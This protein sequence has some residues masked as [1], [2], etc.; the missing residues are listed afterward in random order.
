MYDVEECISVDLTIPLFLHVDIFYQYFFMRY[1]TVFCLHTVFLGVGTL[2][3][4]C[5]IYCKIIANG[6]NNSAR[7]CQRHIS[8]SEHSDHLQFGEIDLS[9][10]N[11]IIY[12]LENDI[13]RHRTAY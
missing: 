5:M 6:G 12:D 3:H 10:V 8:A 1:C 2:N 9:F 11:G 7:N 4:Y 13:V